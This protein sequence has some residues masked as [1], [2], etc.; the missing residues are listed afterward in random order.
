MRCRCLR[1][2]RSIGLLL[3]ACVSA[4]C[5]S[6]G[7]SVAPAKGTVAF[8]GS[9]VTEGSITLVPIVADDMKNGGK[10]AKGEV[11]ADGSF[12]LSTYGKFDGAV[13]G[14]HRVIYESPEGMDE[15]AES[16][17]DDEAEPAAKRAHSSTSAK[18]R[19]LQV[20]MGTEV[21]VK[22]GEDNVFQIE[23]VEA[24]T[25]PSEDAE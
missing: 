3:L 8:S 9:P 25:E 10:P 12:V 18:Q 13:V 23:L 14:R 15:E 4:G 22:P 19:Y 11:T 17:S 1:C 24:P 6:E 16:A 21:E 20:R 5:G 7:F 2:F